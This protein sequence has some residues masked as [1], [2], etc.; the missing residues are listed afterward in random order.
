MIPRFARW[1][2]LV[3]MLA[4]AE[5]LAVWAKGEPFLFI[6]SPD[7]EQ[8]LR[9]LPKSAQQ[10]STAAFS[11]FRVRP[12]QEMLA[13]VYVTNPTKDEE[14]YDRS[15][16][17][18]LFYNGELLVSSKKFDIQAGTTKKVVFEVDPTKKIEKVSSADLL[19]LARVFDADNPDKLEEVKEAEANF[20]ATLLHPS[21]YVEIDNSVSYQDGEFKIGLRLKP[22]A[23]IGPDSP[24]VKV[25]LDLDPRRIPG[26][27]EGS[28][29]AQT[30]KELTAA[31]RSTVLMA[32]NLKFLPGKTKGD[33]AV[34][35]DGLRRVFSF[36]GD[37]DTSAGTSATFTP[38]QKK[39]FFV[40]ERAF[41]I[42]DPKIKPT[43]RVA[44]Q[45]VA[46]NE[47]LT[48][49]INN[50]TIAPILKG[51]YERTLTLTYADKE[52]ALKLASRTQEWELPIPSNEPGKLVLSVSDKDAELDQ[53][54]VFLDKT[55]PAVTIDAPKVDPIKNEAQIKKGTTL[56]VIA[57]AS[58]DPDSD[59]A[60]AY[61]YL[62]KTPD[63]LEPV[64]L[65]KTEG[66]YVVTREFK[67]VNADTVLTVRFVNSAK[68]AT[69]KEIAIK[70]V[71][72][73]AAD[74]TN[75]SG[76]G[77]P[78]TSPQPTP[79]AKVGKILGKVTL[80][81]NPQPGLTV[82]LKPQKGEAQTTQTDEKGN[83]VFKDVPFGEYTLSSIKPRDKS[84]GETSVTVSSE[85]PVKAEILLRR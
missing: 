60:E 53:V 25:R 31:Q 52:Q 4:L 34:D 45:G 33:V 48:I 15:L 67:N 44:T 72:E 62:G 69:Q 14:G 57:T 6:G 8:T 64:P 51:G 19:L 76:M 38:L 61:V 79:K 55:P 3:G 16:V 84:K 78:G 28:D 47:E 11:Q 74:E 43:F 73:V 82:T 30:A 13:S 36:E 2:A 68:M 29:T 66:K 41:N 56:K 39:A 37:F 63:N 35:V 85:K 32:K 5:P 71:T 27:R 54:T 12:N 59:V 46:A 26:L 65:Q 20:K 49:R 70:A 23:P 58:E 9:K 42:S 81:G 80:A 24:P 75:S 1:M 21:E 18:R 40:V 77:T 10:A 50:Q 17:V 83:F 22:D 7:V